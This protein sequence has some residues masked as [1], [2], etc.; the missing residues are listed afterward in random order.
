MSHATVMVKLTAKRLAAHRVHERGLVTRS[1]ID[2]A[3]AE[4]MAPY[5]EQGDDKR[6]RVFEDEE[7][8]IRQRYATESTTKIRTPE[9]DLLW[10]WDNRFR[11]PGSFGMGSDT[12]RTPADCQEVEVPFKELYPT[13]E[14]FAED[15]IGHS[16]RDPQHKR[17][18]HW[19]NPNAKWDWYVIGGRWR[20]YFPIKPGVTA[21]IGEAGAFDNEATPGHSDIVKIGDIDM[22]AVD[23]TTRARAEKFWS[24]WQAW[25][26]GT[27]VETDPFS[28]PRSTAL[29]IGLLDVAQ[30]PALSDHTQKAISW[31]GQVPESDSR[32]DWHDVAKIMDRDAF[33]DRY[34]DCFN[35]IKTFAALDSDGW[36]EPGRMGW[37]GCASDT[38]DQYVTFAR[39]FMGRFVKNTGPDDLLVAVDYH[40]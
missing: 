37:F 18:G 14:A 11:V 19:H 24:E 16:E 31:A 36:H 12:H 21:T 15:Y 22:D 30:G 7:D 5:N 23:C 29:R 28:G 9:G 40:I 33:M 8:E 38:P 35:P 4:M 27:Y 1:A 39:E 20:G 34:L 26:A 13:L 3:L 32:K 6:F 10:S 2:T 25:L 17:Y